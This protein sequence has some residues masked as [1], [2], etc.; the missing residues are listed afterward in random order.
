M[1]HRVSG[2]SFHAVADQVVLE[3]HTFQRHVGG[4]TIGMSTRVSVCREDV[5]L[6]TTVGLHNFQQCHGLIAQRDAVRRSYLVR[7]G[8]IVQT[9]LSKS[10]SA[11]RVI[12]ASAGR[13]IMCNCHSIR[14]RIV[15]LILRSRK[16]QKPAKALKAAYSLNRRHK[17]RRPR[18][19]SS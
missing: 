12:A 14:Q 7:S 13:V 3:A 6:M 11:L 10:M 4:M 16:S 18:A 15:R 8:G 5:F 1:N 19:S 9:R 17:K 2:M